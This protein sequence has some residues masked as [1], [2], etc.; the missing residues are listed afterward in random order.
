MLRTATAII[1]LITL[2]AAISAQN[3]HL[4]VMGGLSNYNG[5]LHPKFYALGQ[6]KFHIAL[7]AK[8]DVSEKIALRS[9]FTYGT[10]Q[11]NDARGSSGNKSRNLNFKSKIMEFQVGAEYHLFSFNDQWW[12]PYLFAG[13]GLYSF[14]PYTATGGKTY[15]KPLGTEGQG[16]SGGPKNYA[17]T[18][19]CIPFG[20]GFKYA[21][22]EDTRVGIEF[23]FR[24][25][26]T[27]Y[28]DDVSGT[29]YNEAGLLAGKGAQAVAL[30]YGGSGAYPAA[31]TLRGNSAAKDWYYFTALTFSTRLILDKY[32]RIAGLAQGRKPKKVGCPSAKGIF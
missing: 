21:L 26:L 15:L 13:V 9:H 10:V 27:D 1:L 24:K 4:S 31:G 22:D 23:G 20:V 5:D 19:L 28:L 25:L 16:L 29:Y 2:P 17:T 11:G 7:G 14:K 6:S 3:L 8:Y 30:A 12:T 32:K 18:Q